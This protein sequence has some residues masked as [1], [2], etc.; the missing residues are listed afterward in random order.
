[1]RRCLGWELYLLLEE[2]CDSLAR[3][4]GIGYFE[5][6]FGVLLGVLVSC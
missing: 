4:I 2:V 5:L 3:R 6:A 1:M